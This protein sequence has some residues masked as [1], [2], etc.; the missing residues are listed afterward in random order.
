MESI[1]IDVLKSKKISRKKFKSRFYAIVALLCVVMIVSSVIS[2]CSYRKGQKFG[3]ACL[4]VAGSKSG[5]S[6]IYSGDS[7]K[8]Q[9]KD[10][11]SYLTKTYPH[12]TLNGIDDVY[13]SSRSSMSKV[14]SAFADVMEDGGY[15][16][17]F[18]WNIEDWFLCTNYFSY[19]ATFFWDN[20]ICI[21]FYI[22]LL[23][24]IVW[25][26]ITSLEDKKEIIVNEDSIICKTNKKKSKQLMISDIV[27]VETAKKKLRLIANGFKFNISNIENSD[28]LKTEI[29]NQKSKLSPTNI[30]N[31][32]AQSQKIDKID[33][34]KKYKDLLD[35][36]VIT[37]EEFDTKKAEFLSL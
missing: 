14:R 12:I 2:Y 24:A 17:F 25:T 36:G 11:Y 32:Q 15:D 8:E 29:M 28:E 16:R 19:F 33:E 9:C 27:S 37:Q 26:I 13:S 7:F 20:I 35:M 31:T 6:V 23:L 10:A 4:T 3:I 21:A 30:V 22:V 34:L 1:T 18:S 5:T